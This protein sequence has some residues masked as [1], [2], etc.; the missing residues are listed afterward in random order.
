MSS[1][2]PWGKHSCESCGRPLNPDDPPTRAWPSLVLVETGPRRQVFE[3]PL[4]SVIRLAVHDGWILTI[5]N[6]DQS[7]RRDWR[8]FQQI[9]NEVCG[10][11][12]VGMEC[13]PP[14]GT[15]M[16]PSNAFIMRVWPLKKQPF[17]LGFERGE[18]LA[19][20]ESMAPQ[21]SLEEAKA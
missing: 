5:I 8:E 17:T 20:Q 14:D 15:V 1:T 9:K 3:N 12:C 13:Y 19:P 4:Y 16:D 2:N 6:S 7:A 21:R 10:P 18:I 11:S